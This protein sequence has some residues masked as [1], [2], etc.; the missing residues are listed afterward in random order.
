LPVQSEYRNKIWS[1]N[2]CYGWHRFDADPDLHVDADTDPDRHQND[3]DSDPDWHQ[4]D[5][6]P[7][8]DPT[9]SFTRL[10]NSIF[11]L[12]LVK[13]LPVN[14]VLSFSSGSIMS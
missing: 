11:F 12:L 8:A 9:P 5:A 4:N 10:E 2:L 7:H 3:A 6:D 1:L 14:N 13:T